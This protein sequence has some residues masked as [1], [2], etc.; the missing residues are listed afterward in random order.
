MNGKTLI[1]DTNAVI[2][3]LD[4]EACSRFLDEHFP[5]NVR[6]ISVITQIELLSYPDITREA[7]GLIRSFLADIPI[8][9]I[10][11]GIVET[12]I[13]IRRSKPS[14]KL[15]DAVIAATAIDCDA[16]LVTNDVDLL[17]LIWAGLRAVNIE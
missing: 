3:L 16:L 17:K 9:A 1:L 13:Q 5:G 11:G 10:E 12:A 8:I 4:N 15:P 7:D 14:V 6:C 2:M